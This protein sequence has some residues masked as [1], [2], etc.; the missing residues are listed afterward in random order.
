MGYLPEYSQ[1]I[2]NYFKALNKDFEKAFELASK[3]RKQGK[4]PC[5]EVE[6]K[7]APDV[8]ARVE[9]LVGPKGVAER[10]REL[11]KEKSREEVCVEL[12]KEIIE[13]ELKKGE[14]DEK[15]T[16]NLITQCVRTG[17][18]L[19]TEGVVSA[20]IEGVSK[21]RVRKNHD[22]SSHVAVY[23]A[24]P[25]RGAGGTGQA[26]TVLMADYCRKLLGITEYRPTQDE[27]QRYIEEIGLYSMKTR[28]GQYTPTEEE[29]IHIVTN[30]PVCI[31][32]EATEEYEVSVHK[33]LPSVETN[34]VRGGV[35]LVLSEGICL[36]AAKVLKISKKIGLEWNWVEKLIKV[37][38]K[39]TDKTEIKPNNK[40]IE[41]LVAGRP[42]FAY[43]MKE[44]GFGMKYGRTRFLGIASKGIHPAT[45]QILDCF[46]AFGTQVKIERPGKGC[47][48]TPC[49][50]IA[51]PIV[52]LKNGEVKEINS[53]EEAKALRQDIEKILYLGN[54]LVSYGDFLKANHPLVQCCFCEDWFKQELR[55]AGVEKSIKEIKEMRFEEAWE[56][57]E[58]KGVSL[59]PKYTFHWHDL[60]KEEIKKLG[61]TLAKQEIVYDWFE[62]KELK[63]NEVSE[64]KEILEKLCVPHKMIEGKAIIEKENA[65]ALLKSLGLLKEK[66]IDLTKFNEIM[67]Q[68]KEEE[69]GV[70]LVNKLSGI[71][72]RKKIG[73]YVGASMGRPE[74]SKERKMQPPVNSLFPVKNYGGRTRSLTK[75]FKML[76]EMPGDNS[77]E[78]EL[79]NYY[80]PIC[81]RKTPLR[82]CDYCKEETIIKKQ[83]TKCSKMHSKEKE[84]CDCGGSLVASSK[85]RI[86]FIKMF[87]QASERIGGAP[88]EI[89]GVIGLISENKVY[90]EIEKGMLRAKYSLSVFRDGTIRHDATEVP[91]THF[92]PKEIGLTLEKLR[93]LGYEKDAYGKEIESEEQII[94]LKT[95]DIILNENAGEY[96]TRVA[97][98]IDDLLVYYYNLPSFYN[99]KK[100]EELIG[101]LVIG[102]APHTSAGVLGR[103]I[104][105]TKVRGIIAHPYFHCACRRNCDGDELC[106]MLL[107]DGLLNFS[108]QFL[109]GT[110]GGQM[111]APLVLTTKINPKE[112]D[113]EVHA[114]D[115]CW[116]Y[117][118]EFYEAGL[119]NLMP[120]EVKIE[121]VAE[122]IKKENAYEGFGF[123]N[124]AELVEPFETKYVQL[125]DMPQ[126]VEEELELMKKIS[127]V[128]LRDAAERIILGHFFPDLY[129]NLRSFSRQKFRC[130]ECNQKYRRVPLKGKCLKCGGKLVLTVSRGSIEKYLQISLS[131]IEK[132]ELPLYLK[133][134]ILLLQK[135]IKSIFEDEKV[136]QFSLADYV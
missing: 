92:I 84:E 117:P 1:A 52:R 2:E 49:E 39:E 95:Q 100:K 65:L 63:I 89:K 77:I 3:A 120:S 30:C 33:N 48:V 75:A 42:I 134:R 18:A 114:M 88:E 104:G 11:S 136:K 24:G 79:A 14:L 99:L 131:L 7:P 110:T 61:E 109:P 128:D 4:D 41:E 15:K 132:Y 62:L 60:K 83:C 98:F 111:D 96:L 66:R 126:K 67:N 106:V 113:D 44:G 102:L 119:R 64:L 129:G 9:E 20:P 45:M 55:R 82:K 78:L 46:P 12:A 101:Q 6:I 28:A 71:T 70:E 40:Y 47:I 38:K 108:K 37:A 76:K 36:K 94:E 51:G 58:K 124:S 125:K 31:T 69:K 103:I 72:I 85:Q 107:M 53:S 10:I 22:G 56:L 25:I 57:A 35:Y 27:V 116:E 123:T 93:E 90:E 59:A 23:F 135:E 115:V 121:T 26:F 13:E 81:G 21:V 91:A 80:C 8:A 34:R 68:A 43:P 122:R 87:A 32:G 127:A 105:F 17:L 112:V 133:Q 19:F 16:E 5:K 54:I 97:L 118:I 50:N 86:D 74:K 130:I 73:V 29:I